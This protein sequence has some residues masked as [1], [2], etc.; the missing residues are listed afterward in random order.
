MA[1]ERG[2]WK[3]NVNVEIDDC[4]REHI[5]H[6]IIEGYNEGEICVTDQEDE[7]EKADQAYRAKIEGAEE[8]DEDIS[9]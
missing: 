6:C 3:L 8:E 4:D 5:A 9:D 2:W 7:E 1:K